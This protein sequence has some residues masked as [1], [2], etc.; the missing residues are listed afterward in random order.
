MQVSTSGF[1]SWLIKLLIIIFIFGVFPAMIVVIA[2]NYNT[3]AKS[4]SDVQNALIERHNRMNDSANG[5]RGSAGANNGDETFRILSSEEASNLQNINSYIAG[6]WNNHADEAEVFSVSS[7]GS[8]D[9]FYSNKKTGYGLWS[10]DVLEGMYFVIKKRLGPTDAGDYFYKINYLDQDKMI[11]IKVKKG[12]NIDDFIKESKS[13]STNSAT[14][15]ES[16]ADQTTYYK[17]Y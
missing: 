11:L 5:T 2:K 17:V 8:Y 16:N 13:Y 7:N 14:E 15:E 12:Q 6:T 10:A 4:I 3:K 1:F 9:E